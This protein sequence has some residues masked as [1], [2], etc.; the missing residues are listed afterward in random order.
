VVSVIPGLSVGHVT[1]NRGLTGCTV[2][3]PEGPATGALEIAGRAAA[4]HGLEFLDP[5]HLAPT[6]DAIVLAGGSAYGL[7]SIWGVMQWLEERGRGFAVS[8]TVVPHV[9]GAIIFDLSVGDHRVR[10]DRAMGHAAAAAASAGPVAEGSVGAGTGATV[11][12][13]YGIERAMRGGLGVARVDREGIVTAALMV[14]NA[15]GDV[16]D[17]ATG[18]LLAGARDAPDGRRLVDTA[19]ALAA[20]AGPPRFR[21][22]H[23]TIGVVATTGGLSK[24]EAA[25]VARLGL[26]GFGRALSPPHLDTDGDCLFC[27]S[28]GAQPADVASVGAAAAEVV[29]TAIARAVLCATPLPGL[30]TARDIQG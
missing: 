24:A 17:P 14:V 10:P 28:I 3:M 5:R 21:P 7:E 9:A 16:R 1:D 4:V 11:G 12:K 6:V 19:A 8:R 27:L 13:L 25:R 20:G 2:I 30:P 26:A 22:A 23:T 18:R 15:V 29:A